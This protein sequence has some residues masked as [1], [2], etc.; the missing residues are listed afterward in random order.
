MAIRSDPGQLRTL[1]TFECE[2]KNLPICCSHEEV[3]ENSPKVRKVRPRPS[4]IPSEPERAT[5]RQGEPMHGPLVCRKTVPPL[6][7]P[8]RQPPLRKGLMAVE[9][10]PY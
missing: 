4:Y 6:I 10:R 7:K 8:P 2:N 3:S 5:S 1:R 9:R